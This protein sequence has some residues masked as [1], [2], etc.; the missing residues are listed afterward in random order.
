MRGLDY[1]AGVPKAAAVRG[2]GFDFVIR[3]VGTPGRRKN[4]TAAEYRDMT[5]AGVSVALVFENWAGD[6]L[7][8]RAAGAR[9]ARAA[10]DD[11][12]SF[13]WPDDRPLYMAVDQD[14]TTREPDA[15]RRRVPA[16]RGRR[17]RA[18]SGSGSTARPTSS[19]VPTTTASPA[20]SG[21]SKAWS[22]KRVSPHAHVV[23][24][25]ETVRVDGVECDVNTTD[26]PEFGQHPRP[27]EQE[28]RNALLTVHGAVFH[29]GGDAGPVSIIKRL[30]DLKASVDKITA[31]LP[32]RRAAT[33]HRRRT[34]R[35]PR[36][37][38]SPHRRRGRTRR[39]ASS[40]ADSPGG[41]RS[42]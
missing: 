33:R 34:G 28:V 37:R 29:G 15:H 31:A 16:R 2:A 13:G 24:Q 12:R 3:Y 4:I 41:P 6:A 27:Q 10:L 38:G 9:N 30:D 22:R 8:G 20:G 26:R 11:A 21:Q 5:G 39:P 36:P 1:S 18:S 19:T 32:H 35:T 42:R 40:P 17:T 14:I 23:Q 7:A 25:T